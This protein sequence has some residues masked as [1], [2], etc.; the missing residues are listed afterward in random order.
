[1]GMT[2]G[3]PMPTRGIPR[4]SDRL[5]DVEVRKLIYTTNGIES[6]NARFRAAV[7]GEGT[8][9]PVPP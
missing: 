6:L 7:P 8:S 9:R 5:Y 2:G 3:R 1:M 4:F